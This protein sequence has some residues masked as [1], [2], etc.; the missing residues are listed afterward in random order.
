VECVI[1]NSSDTRVKTNF[2]HRV[3]LKK[4]DKMK[5]AYP[6][7]RDISV[8]AINQIVALLPNPVKHKPRRSECISSALVFDSP[9]LS[10]FDPVL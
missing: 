5:F 7:E 4:S 1:K 9:K 10:T 2:L 3:D 8:H 6:D